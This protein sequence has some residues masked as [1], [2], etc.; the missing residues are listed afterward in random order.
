MPKGHHC[1][2]GAKAIGAD[3]HVIDVDAQYK[4]YIASLEKAIGRPLTWEHDDLALQNIQARKQAQIALEN[5]TD[6][7]KLSMTM[8]RMNAW[9]WDRKEDTLEFAI[10][11]GESTLSRALTNG[12]SS[13]ESVPMFM[14]FT[15]FIDTVPALTSPKS[16]GFGSAIRSATWPPWS[17]SWTRCSRGRMLE[18]PEARP[19]DGRYRWRGRQAF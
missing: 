6:W 15:S 9:R 16:M 3:F 4:A 10:V 14:S 2:I 5:S 7:L 1:R 19:R 11:D 12:H 13:M 18:S 8:V 17:T